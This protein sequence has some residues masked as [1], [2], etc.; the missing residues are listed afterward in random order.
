MEQTMTF[1]P[2]SKV[3]HPNMHQPVAQSGGIMSG[4]SVKLV[5]GWKG[6]LEKLRAEICWG[7]LGFLQWKSVMSLFTPLTFSDGLHSS[8]WMP[9]PFQCTRYFEFPL[10]DSA[11]YDVFYFVFFNSV[12]YYRG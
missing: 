9:F 12:A 3:Q 2:P 5:S 1:T 10:E 8:S 4:V 6:S 11:V 7:A